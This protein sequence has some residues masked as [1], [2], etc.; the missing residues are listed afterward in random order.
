M[1]W[2]LYTKSGNGVES[3]L[4]DWEEL[5]VCHG[6]LE[7]KLERLEYDEAGVLLA[8]TTGIS[9]ITEKTL[10]NAFPH[11]VQGEHRSPIADKL[12]GQRLV[13]LSVGHFEWDSETHCASERS[14]HSL[15]SFE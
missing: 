6:D 13:V 10:Y 2:N 15:V 11:L 7:I 3:L 8:K 1:A 5:R 4:A 14:H 12:L 9:T